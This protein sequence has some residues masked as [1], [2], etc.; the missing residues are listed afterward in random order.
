MYQEKQGSTIITVQKGWTVLFN[1]GSG[2]K[3][4]VQGADVPLAGFLKDDRICIFS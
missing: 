3:E 4:R 2:V 1:F